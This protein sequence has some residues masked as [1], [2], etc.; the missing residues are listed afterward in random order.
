[1]AERFLELLIK[2]LGVRDPYEVAAI[3][4]TTNFSLMQWENI[5]S[6]PYSSTFSCLWFDGRCQ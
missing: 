6:H 2:L 1:M 3:S 5:L 4:R